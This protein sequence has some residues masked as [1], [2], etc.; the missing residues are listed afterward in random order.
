[1]TTRSQRDGVPNE[2]RERELQT[3]RRRMLRDIS[4]LVSLGFMSGVLGSGVFWWT[5]SSVCK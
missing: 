2:V 3:L 1:M 5:L 4:T